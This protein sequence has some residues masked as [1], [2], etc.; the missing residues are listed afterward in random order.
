M[1]LESPIPQPSGRDLLVRVEAV[2]VNPVDAK[3]RSAKGTI[4]SLPRILGWDDAG[5][6]ETVGPGVTL[7]RAGDAAHYAED[8]FRPGSN[9]QYQLVDERIVA[10]KLVSLDAPQTAAVPLAAITAY[11]A[12][13]DRLGIDRSRLECGMTILIIEGTDGVG[14]MEIQLAKL[15]G[16]TVLA[17]AS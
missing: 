11:E 3:I 5:I 4:K 8:I 15:A 7:F 9:I 1:D 12:L 13:F 17:T 2:S 14:S 6:V 16:L 10:H